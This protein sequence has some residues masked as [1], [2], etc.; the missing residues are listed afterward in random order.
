MSSADASLGEFSA[1]DNASSGAPEIPV[2][3]ADGAEQATRDAGRSEVWRPRGQLFG[4]F[5]QLGENARIHQAE[6]QIFNERP[7][8]A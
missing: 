2:A 8:G 4:D 7:E 5:Y 3:N 6:I 1:T